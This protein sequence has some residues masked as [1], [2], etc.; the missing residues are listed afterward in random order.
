MSFDYRATKTRSKKWCTLELIIRHGKIV[1]L[2]WDHQ[3]SPNPIILR[4]YLEFVPNNGDASE[5]FEKCQ[6]ENND[7]YLH[8]RTWVPSDA[9]YGW[10]RGPINPLLMEHQAEYLACINHRLLKFL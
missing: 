3:S 5:R 7:V 6:C 4:I 1:C 2:A 8:Y 10:L 9:H